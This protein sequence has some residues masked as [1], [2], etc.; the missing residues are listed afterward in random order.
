MDLELVQ[1]IEDFERLSPLRAACA[2]APHSSEHMAHTYFSMGA[3]G[4]NT[5]REN[6]TAWSD[7]RLKPRVT[8]ALFMLRLFVAG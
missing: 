2:S 3:E 7:L 4:E 5:V 8:P 1:S 6:R